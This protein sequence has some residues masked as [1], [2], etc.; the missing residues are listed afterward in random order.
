MLLG[1]ADVVLLYCTGILLQSVLQLG[2]LDSVI[3]PF[4][5]TICIVITVTGCSTIGLLVCNLYTV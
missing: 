3:V 1:S 5:S 2:V 4:T